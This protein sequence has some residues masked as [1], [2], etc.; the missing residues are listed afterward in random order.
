MRAALAAVLTLVAATPASA[1]PLQSLGRASGPVH[2]DDRHVAWTPA[3]GTTRVRDTATGATTDV[4]NPAGCARTAVGAGPLLFEC[5]PQG[6]DLA[7]PAIVDI[8]TRDERRPFTSD[9]IRHSHVS[10]EQLRWVGIGRHWLHA[11]ASGYH[12]S[13]VS[14]F[15]DWR[16]GA[17]RWDDAGPRRIP[18]LDLPGLFAP[19]CRPLTR[20]ENEQLAYESTNRYSAPFA[21]RGGWAL[22]DG[23]R[24]RAQRCGAAKPVTLCATACGAARGLGPGGRVAWTRRRT[25]HARR[26][27]TRRA[28][29]WRVPA[30]T[31]V[32]GV[33]LHAVIAVSG[34]RLLLG[35]TR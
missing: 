3:A 28:W 13:G 14:D 24:V 27:G 29:S 5:P 26:L 9:G 1:A 12:Y 18:N 7:L 8:A 11:L 23:R 17:R 10:L 33:T 2:V 22:L 4:T 35:A 30:G 34:G 31:S 19:L 20:R 21:Y 32:A 16:D 6:I 25:L 15:Y